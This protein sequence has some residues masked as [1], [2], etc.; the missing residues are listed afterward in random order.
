MH[1]VN[2]LLS[3]IIILL[4]TCVAYPLL[5]TDCIAGYCERVWT[6]TTQLVGRRVTI[7]T[8]RTNTNVFMSSYIQCSYSAVFPMFFLYLI[9]KFKLSYCS[10][11]KILKCGNGTRELI[12]EL[13]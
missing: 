9:R 12:V 1:A 7:G 6:R 13:S 3:I 8:L 2:V 11:A 5:C 10:F 4:C